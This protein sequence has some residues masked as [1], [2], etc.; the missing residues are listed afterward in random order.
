MYLENIF[1]VFGPL[2]TSKNNN[3]HSRQNR[4]STLNKT[5]NQ[6]YFLNF[7]AA[8]ILIHSQSW[9]GSLSL[10]FRFLTVPPITP[11]LEIFAVLL[12]STGT[13]PVSVSK[14]FIFLAKKLFVVEEL[15]SPV[16][17]MYT[18]YICLNL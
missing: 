10:L 18:I 16:L 3:S 11:P 15:S 13:L 7:L 9:S 6:Y 1:R 12:V 17:A 2:I 14:M 8:N 4:N 5:K